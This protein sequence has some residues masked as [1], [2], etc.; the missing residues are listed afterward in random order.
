MF[1]AAFSTFLLLLKDKYEAWDGGEKS[2][3][4]SFWPN[5]YKS[6][7]QRQ[8][9]QQSRSNSARRNT[10]HGL[11]CNTKHT[12]HTMK[13]RRFNFDWYDCKLGLFLL[14]QAQI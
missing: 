9:C 13:V 5:V 2:G 8:C 1:V 11:S 7:R 14:F 12:Q 6:V 3:F 10:H 4:S